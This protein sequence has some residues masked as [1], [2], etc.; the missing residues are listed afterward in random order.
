MFCGV[1]GMIGAACAQSVLQWKTNAMVDTS[2]DGL[3]MALTIRLVSSAARS[4]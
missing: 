1:T 3:Q 4:L 2:L